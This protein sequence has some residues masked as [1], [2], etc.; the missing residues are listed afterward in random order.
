MRH[1]GIDFDNT[2]VCYDD[3]FYK[4]AVEQKLIPENTPNNKTQIRNFLRSANRED[5]WTQLQGYVYGKKMDFANAFPGVD[6]FFEKCRNDGIKISIISHKTKHPFLGPQYDLHAAAK[7]WLFMQPFFQ[8]QIDVYFELS[9]REKLER[10]SRA[11]CGLFI[12]DLPE[13]LSEPA[14]PSKVLKVLFDPIRQYRESR[15]WMTL[16]SWDQGFSILNSP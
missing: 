1:I 14:F 7:E 10:I 3:V 12:D 8:G 6:R 13:L 15:Q 4:V 5:E 2:I 9:L 16:R 11:G